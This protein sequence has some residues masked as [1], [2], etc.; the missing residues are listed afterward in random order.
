LDSPTEIS[1][2]D[3]DGVVRSLL[4]N[5]AKT[6]MSTIGPEDKFS[7]APIR[8]AYYALCS[9]Q[10]TGSLDAVHG[11]VHNSQYPNQDKVLLSEYGSIGGMRFFVSSLGAVSTVASMLSADVY[12]ISV[13]GMEAYAR[14][15]QDGYAA[16]FIYL[17][18]EFSGPMAMNVSVGWKTAFAAK[19]LNDL[20]LFNLKCTV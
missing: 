16:R 15:D 17:P 1:R 2:T 13:G 14:V 9:T 10:L 18:A 5:N 19:I 8:N 6:I 7:S 4:S 12:N 3:I 11:F 20:W